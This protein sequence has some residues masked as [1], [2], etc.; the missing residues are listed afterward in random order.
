[1]MG[2]L[3]RIEQSAV[4][5]QNMA[6]AI[7]NLSRTRSHVTGSRLPLKDGE[8]VYSKSWLGNTLLEWLAREVAAW[9]GCV[10]PKHEAE[11]LI[12]TL[13]ATEAWTD[14][15]CAEGDK[16]VELDFELAVALANVTEGAARA[17]VLKVTQ[18]EPRHGFGAWQALADGYAPKS[19][20]D[21]AIALQPILATPK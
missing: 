20:N 13:R 10:D 9:L 2:T 18:T 15:R 1:M 3:Q 17:K 14:G 6:D 11:K 19:S 7:E 16:Y 21:P 12:Q 4:L 8:R 5:S